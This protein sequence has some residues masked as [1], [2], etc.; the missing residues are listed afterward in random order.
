MH[1]QQTTCNTCDITWQ[2]K[3]PKGPTCT[4]AFQEMV[5]F[6]CEYEWFE[7]LILEG[8]HIHFIYNNIHFSA[9]TY[10]SFSILLNNKFLYTIMSIDHETSRA[11]TDSIRIRWPFNYV[12]LADGSRKPFTC[13]NLLRLA[14]VRPPYCYHSLL[15]PIKSV[16]LICKYLIVINGSSTILVRKNNSGSFNL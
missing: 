16:H 14:W 9:Y 5:N 6:T 4:Y 8:K 10:N 3:F 12:K 13:I 15:W 2:C 11:F 1:R 7:L